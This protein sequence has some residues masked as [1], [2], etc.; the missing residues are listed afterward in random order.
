[1]QTYLIAMSKAHTK[2]EAMPFNVLARHALLRYDNAFLQ[3]EN[4]IFSFQ[5][6]LISMSNNATFDVK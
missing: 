4:A 5:I 1:M 3:N 2:A 6:T